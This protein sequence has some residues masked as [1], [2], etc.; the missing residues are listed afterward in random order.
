MSEVAKLLGSEEYRSAVPGIA[1]SLA[2]AG[3]V[4]SVFSARML[5]PAL[6]TVGAYLPVLSP[7]Y[8]QQ[9]HW[10]RSSGQVVAV[11][12]HVVS[13]MT[14]LCVAAYQFDA[15][16]RRA[17]PVRHRWLGRL[18]IASG[19][20]VMLSLRWLR[21]SAGAGSARH[22]D[23]LLRWFIDCASLAWV[24]TTAAGWFAM[25]VRRDKALHARCMLLST[26]FALVPVFQRVIDYIMVPL[27]VM[28]RANICLVVGGLPPWRA[29]FGAPGSVLGGPMCRVHEAADA[30][31]APPAPWRERGV[32]MTAAAA[33]DERACPLVFSL[34]GMGEAE[35][36]VFPFSAW[37]GLGSVLYGAWLMIR[38]PSVSAEQL[39]VDDSMV[40]EATPVAVVVERARYAWDATAAGFRTWITRLA[41]FRAGGG[42]A[43]PPSEGLVLATTSLFM[44]AVPANVV[45]VLLFFMWAFAAVFSACT[46]PISWLV[47]H[48][49][50]ADAASAGASMVLAN[51]GEAW[52]TAMAALG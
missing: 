31:G 13:G 23:P 50:G 5:V 15:P 2:V 38:H 45:G 49:V 3:V 4:F 40:H 10:L 29:R 51:L 19:G 44:I 22:G 9:E 41:A 48:L 16:R 11:I 43:E 32:R 37:M 27:A 52:R 12:A 36:A 1:V 24:A 7:V 33:H 39:G 26:G 21:V 42:P 18:Y 6:W 17:S 30:E 47:V 8:R 34:D 25:A 46:L 28:L 20:I 14:L 35:Q